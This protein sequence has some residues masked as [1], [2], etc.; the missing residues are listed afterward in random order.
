MTTMQREKKQDLAVSFSSIRHS[1]CRR[2]FVGRISYLGMVKKP[3]DR[4][5]RE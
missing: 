1:V 5:Q 3:A 4:L 2:A